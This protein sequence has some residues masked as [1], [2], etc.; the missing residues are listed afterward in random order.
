M[1]QWL[2]NEWTNI[3][4]A[5]MEITGF[6]EA[7]DEAIK[8]FP[9]DILKIFE[10]IKNFQGF[11]LRNLEI[12]HARN[13][14]AAAFKNQAFYLAYNMPEKY[15]YLR[16]QL[17]RSNGA[18]S[19]C[20]Q[21]SA[22]DFSSHVLTSLPPEIAYFSNLV[23]LNLEKN[24]LRFFPAEIGRLINLKNLFLNDNQLTFLPLEIGRLT[25][26]TD[27]HIEN[28]Q[29]T[30]LTPEIGKCINIQHLYLSNNRLTS[31]PIQI[32]KLTKLQ[33]LYLNDNRL[34]L[35]PNSIEYLL[36]LKFLLL[37]NNDLAEIPL[38]IQKLVKLRRI[39]FCLNDNL[40]I[41]TEVDKLDTLKCKIYIDPTQREKIDCESQ[42]LKERVK[43]VDY[44]PS[45]SAIVV[46]VPLPPPPLN[47]VIR[48][49]Q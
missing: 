38:E 7:C 25:E 8:S 47:P 2:K 23:A 10:T 27:L 17:Q 35:L 3:H 26:L 18:Y 24:Q 39:D 19:F 34:D 44:L 30:N 45:P 6:L 12:I 29:L 13:E 5:G 15:E 42:E 4:L 43:I 36:N 14:F 32:G 41:Q 33:R 22:I 48:F 31:L 20:L 49:P 21:Y 9:N 28:N 46:Y 11:N 40:P 1:K 16:Q 37:N